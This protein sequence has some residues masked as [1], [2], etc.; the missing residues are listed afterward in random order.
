MNIRSKKKF[1]ENL[2]PF[3]KRDKRYF[4]IF[5]FSFDHLSRNYKFKTMQFSIPHFG[6]IKLHT[7][8]E[9]KLQSAIPPLL[10]RYNY[11]ISIKSVFLSSKGNKSRCKNDA[12]KTKERSKQI[13]FTEIIPRLPRR[14]KSSFDSRTNQFP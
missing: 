10:Q 12:T 7:M 4:F 11:S 8:N 14:A 13:R 5:N 3:E 1:L 2:Y 9:N 6:Y